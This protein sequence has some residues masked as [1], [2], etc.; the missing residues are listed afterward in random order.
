[1]V[2]GQNLHL[3]RRNHR[4][5]LYGIHPQLGIQLTQSLAGLQQSQVKEAEANRV[6][7]QKEARVLMTMGGVIVEMAG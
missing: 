3:Q 6:N 2:V 7:H 5:N 1:M 4:I